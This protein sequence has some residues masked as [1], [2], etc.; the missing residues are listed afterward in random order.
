MNFRERLADLK[1]ISSKTKGKI[2]LWESEIEESQNKIQEHN[3][4]LVNVAKA[5]EVLQTATEARR[6]ELRDRV[7]T[8][9]TRGLRAVFKRQ[10]F[11]F[12]FKVSLKRDIFGVYPVLRSDFGE[13]QI[14]ESIADGHGGGV[15]DVVSFILKVIILSLARPKIAPLM[16]LDESFKHVSPAYLRGV[17]GLIKELAETA[18]IQFI[19]VT[20]K[21]E[22]LDSADVIYKSSLNDD[23]TT[24][25]S[26]EHDLRDDIYHSP[27]T[28]KR[29]VRESLF[30]HEP[31]TKK[32]GGDKT[33]S[34]NPDSYAK[35]ERLKE[36]KGKRRKK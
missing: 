2:E 32:E 33:Y 4:N 16:I 30:D 28:P 23:G 35:R 18:N 34:K 17:S 27:E 15:A 29:R 10:D 26:L 8:L 22:L 31:L 9:V 19:M 7:E 13:H 25:F 12:V 3:I 11:E 21:P 24:E 20:H 1:V 36:K 5:I 6:E 14:E